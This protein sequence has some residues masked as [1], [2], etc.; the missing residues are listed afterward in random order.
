M[1]VP[2]ALRTAPHRSSDANAE[3]FCSFDVWFWCVW[4]NR[5]A[6]SLLNCIKKLRKNPLNIN[7]IVNYYIC[8]LWE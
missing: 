5:Q 8:K 4:P 7:E 1:A 6:Q 3:L 2:F